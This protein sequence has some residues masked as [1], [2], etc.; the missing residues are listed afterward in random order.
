[1]KSSFRVTLS[2][3]CL[4]MLGSLPLFAYGLALEKRR[5]WAWVRTAQAK[6]ERVVLKLFGS[7]RQVSWRLCLAPALATN[8]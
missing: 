6:T 4:G 8:F 7:R 3:T 2:G 1:M 5:D